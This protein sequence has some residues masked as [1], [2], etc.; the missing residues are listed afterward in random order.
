M[1]T[2]SLDTAK[3]I[4]FVDVTEKIE[5]ELRQKNIVSGNV[6]LHVPHTT[7]AITINENYDPAVIHDLLMIIDR[8]IPAKANYLHGEGNSAAHIKSS[9]FGISLNVMFEKGKL[10]LGQW[11]GLFFCEFD[12]PR[13]REIWCWVTPILG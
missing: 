9:L 11:Q 13:T 2:I 10:K 12:G 4:Q 1:I 3:K 6:C 7:A 8:L 5:H